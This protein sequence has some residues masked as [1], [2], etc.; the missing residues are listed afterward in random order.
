MSRA[1]PPLRLARLLKSACRSVVASGLYRSG[2]LGV[3]RRSERSRNLRQL[4]RLRWRLEPF[5]GSKFVILCYHRIGT[6]GVPLFSRLRRSVFASQMKYVRKHYRVVSLGQLYAEI[7]E[8][9]KVPP[10]LAVTFD[11]GYRDLYTHAFPVLQEY[12][13]QATIYLIGKSMQTGEAPWYDRIFAALSVTKM[14]V[15]EV[16]LDNPRQFVLSDSAAWF[17]AAWEIICH[18]RSISN[19]ARIKW[20]ADFEKRVNVPEAMVRE[21]ILT[22]EQARTMQKAGISFGAHTMTHPAVSRLNDVELEEELGASKSLIENRLGT[23]VD[24]FAFP[25]G[26]PDDRSSASELALSRFGYRSAVTTT[27]GLNLAFTN[28]L[29]LSRLQI[30][31][32]PSIPN[33]ALTLSRTFLEVSRQ[34]SEPMDSAEFD[35]AH[36]RDSRANG[37]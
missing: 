11:D 16:E 28:P 24:D 30:G 14:S 23:A 5:Q 19:E 4:G 35:S 21:R 8:N 2:L 27:T 9:A 32:D 25:F 36:Q 22:W 6:E 31:D 29:R 18:L 20:C 33:F 17:Q 1:R 12:G 3:L 13:V 34:V 26:K 7:R 37:Y 15:V 10:T